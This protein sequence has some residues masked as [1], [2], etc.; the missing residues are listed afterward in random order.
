MDETRQLPPRTTRRTRD[1]PPQVQ[2]PLPFDDES[3]H[4]VPYALTTRARREVAPEAVPDL[5]VVRR[6][7]V[8]A[9]TGT[10]T[11]GSLD[12]PGDTR[13]S[14]ARALRRAGMPVSAIARTLDVDELTVRAWLGD[15]AGRSVPGRVGTLPGMAASPSPGSLTFERARAHARATA[16]DRLEQDPSF[17]AGLGLLAGIADV[18]EHSVGVSTDDPRVAATLVGWLLR[19]TDATPGRIRVVLRLAPTAAADLARHR[20]AEAMGLGIEQ[21]AHTRSRAEVEG[22][23]QALVRLADPEVAGTVTGWSQAL[24]EPPSP[25]PLDAA[26]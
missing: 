21:V 13:S 1:T 17:A 24:L 23:E 22:R 19:Y 14:R 20:W 12:E 6:P 18:D 15:L 26:F 25:E 5:A 2:Q 11:P 8:A 10:E 9:D 3:E 16:A 4:P 7:G